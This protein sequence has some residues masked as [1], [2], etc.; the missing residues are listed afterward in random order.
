M[1]LSHSHPTGCSE[2]RAPARPF[3]ISPVETEMQQKGTNGE[4]LEQYDGLCPSSIS[5]CLC[6]YARAIAFVHNLRRQFIDF[7]H[8]ISLCSLAFVTGLHHAR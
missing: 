3:D 1:G 5:H 4:L 7:P 2:N 8:A 6:N